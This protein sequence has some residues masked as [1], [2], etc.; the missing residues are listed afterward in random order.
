MNFVNESAFNYHEFEA[1]LE[2]T[3][4]EYEETVYHTNVSWLNEGSASQYLD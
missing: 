4:N 2:A 3:E 1:L